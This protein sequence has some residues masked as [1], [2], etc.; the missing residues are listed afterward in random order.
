MEC[1]FPE[2]TNG[3]AEQFLCRYMYQLLNGIKN[4]FRQNTLICAS[5]TS[6]GRLETMILSAGEEVVVVRGVAAATV[7]RARE[8]GLTTGF[9]RTWTRAAPR[10]PAPRRTRGLEEIICWGRKDGQGGV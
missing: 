10:R 5:F 2:R 9:P 7:A 3:R 4:A 8:A 1:D 6:A